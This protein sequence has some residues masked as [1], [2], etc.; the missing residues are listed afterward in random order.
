MNKLLFIWLM[1][2]LSSCYVG[3]AYKYRKFELKDVNKLASVTLTKSDAPFYFNYSVKDNSA[4]KTYLDTS[5]ANSESYAFLVIRNDSILYENYFQGLDSSDIFPS[6]SVAKSFVGSLIQIAH[7]EGKIKSLDE[8]VTNY[9]PYLLKNDKRFAA[10]TI[11]H[12]LDMRSGIKSNENYSN[13]FSDVLKIGFTKNMHGKIKK[14][15]I[16]TAPGGDFIYKSVNTQVLAFVLEAATNKPLQDYMH[17]KLWLPLGMESD[18]TW[19]IDSKRH[20]TVR[21]FCC[22]N[23]TAKDFAKLG[24]LY[25]KNGNWNGKQIISKD[26][27]QTIMNGD[28]MYKYQGY[29]NQWWSSRAS[30]RFNDSLEAVSFVKQQD[31][32]ERW[33]VSKVERNKVTSYR[34]YSNQP[35]ILAQGILGQY[36]YVNPKKNLIIVRTG[37][38]WSHYKYYAQSFIEHVAD[39]IK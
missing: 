29:K 31:A 24:R 28:T 14:L 8:P 18:A 6:F 9:L 36:I 26:W 22:L 32:D 25:L 16:E 4:L 7:E 23:A 2:I 17:E 30:K 33:Y 10:I 20:N 38:N 27:V 12:V 39:M 21:A 11:Q 19:H 34:A 5:L 15:E 13:P 37:H 3:R 35:A 1:I